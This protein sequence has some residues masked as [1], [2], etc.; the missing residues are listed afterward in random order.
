MRGDG[1]EKRLERVSRSSS[2]LKRRSCPCIASRDEV[3]PL[4]DDRVSTALSWLRYRAPNRVAA[5][6]DASSSLPSSPSC[7]L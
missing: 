6:V 5:S 7:Q 2:L 4:S 1:N 3:S